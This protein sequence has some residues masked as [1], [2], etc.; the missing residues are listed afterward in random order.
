MGSETRIS[1]TLVREG[2]QHYY[3]GALRRR[4]DD[5]VIWEC[6]HEH[7]TPTAALYECAQIEFRARAAAAADRSE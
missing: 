2:A 7:A 3:R 5:A 1:Y 4:S 6:S